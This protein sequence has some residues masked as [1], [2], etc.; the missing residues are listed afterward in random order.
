MPLNQFGAGFE[1]TAKDAASGVFGRVGRNFSGMANKADKNSKVMHGAMARIGKGFALIGIGVASLA[2]L[3]LALN[4]SQKLGKAIAEVST[5][6]D[7]ATF[8]IE[9]MKGLVKGLAGEYGE[10][11]T[12]QAAALYQTISAGYGDAA[13]AAEVLTSANKLAVGGV[14]EVE[15]AV[16]GLTNVLNTY[17]T[18]NLKSADVSDAFFVA[19]KAGKTTVGEL[20]QQIG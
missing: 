10:Q 8:P 1:I 13:K 17:A 5:L 15:T 2:P 3:G 20:S 4:E 16:D 7:E 9:R 19:V 18:Q 14:T 12:S 6:T 11:A